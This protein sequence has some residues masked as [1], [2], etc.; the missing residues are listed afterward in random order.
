M[1]MLNQIKLIGLRF[2]GSQVILENTHYKTRLMKNQAIWTQWQ[3]QYLPVWYSQAWAARI[4]CEVCLTD[5]YKVD[6][7]IN[8]KVIN[9]TSDPQ[10]VS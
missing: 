1:L 5:L 2:D 10:L 4:M 9:C 7:V 3:K 6:Q 8:S